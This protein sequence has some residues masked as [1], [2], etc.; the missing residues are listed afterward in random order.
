MSF[1]NLPLSLKFLILLLPPLVITFTC[2]AMG[3]AYLGYRVEADKQQEQQRRIVESYSQALKGPLWD[4]DFDT[5]WGIVHTLVH[6]PSVM[7]LRLMQNCRHKEMQWE[8]APRSA[9][10]GIG[11]TIKQ[12]IV[13]MDEHGR[14]YDVGR[15]EVRFRTTSTS[16][17]MLEQ[18]WKYGMLLVLLFSVM[19]L[20]ALVAN[21]A[22]VTAPLGRF[23]AAIAAHR[24][25]E[26][27]EMSEFEDRGDEL[28]AV[29]Q[30]YSQ[31][32]AALE[33]R[34][35]RKD[36]LASCARL[37]LQGTASDVHVLASVLAILRKAV[38]VD[39]VQLFLN[40]TNNAGELCMALELEDCG[41]DVP[42]GAGES[43]PRELP[44]GQG[45]ERWRHL[46]S[47]GE[48]VAGNM[49][50]F[51]QEE[52]VLL[53]AMHIKSCTAHPIFAGNAWR[54]F[55]CLNEAERARD[56]SQDEVVFLRTA[57]DMVGS[58]FQ[59]S[60]SERR[61][62]Q[63]REQFLSLLDGIPEPIYVSDKDSYELLFV[64]KHFQ[65]CLERDALGRKCYHVLQK[66]DAPCEFCTN[67]IIF[68][69]DGPHFWQFQ[70]PVNMRDYYVIDKAIKW[71]DGRDVRFELAIDITRLKEAETALKE[72]EEKYRLIAENISDI[73]WVLNISRD[74]FTYMS[75]S[76]S[77]VCDHAAEEVM[78]RH[79]SEAFTPE[80]CELVRGFYTRHLEELRQ[81]P[82]RQFQTIVEIQQLCKCGR[83][84]LGESSMRL[85]ATSDGEF[86]VVGVTRSIEERKKHEKLKEDVE[87]MM[88]HDL[89]SPLNAIVGL[90]P[91]IEEGGGLNQEQTEMLRHITEQGY[92][93]LQ[94]IN[95]SLDLYKLETGTYAYTPEPLCLFSIL[96]EVIL[97]VQTKYREREVSVE[98]QHHGQEVDRCQELQV[99]GERLLLY[100][101]F[102]NLID[103]AMEASRPGEHVRVE[104]SLENHD[105]FV[106]IHNQGLVPEVIR[107]RFFDKYVTY[108]KYGGTGLGTYSAKL[109]VEVMG[110][111]IEMHSSPDE[112]THITVGLPG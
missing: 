55:I 35:S 66:K 17:A 112:G 16:E 50:S 75:P 40:T 74:R 4:C 69:Q 108:G 86:E 91:L 8:A 41:Q 33:E 82:E 30:A 72:S 12:N 109:M 11:A 3:T 96:R 92:K 100:S 54:G 49:E 6:L 97:N 34:D 95:F 20:G 37:L 83:P 110:G 65:Q 73:I 68:K 26:Q 67:V 2:G 78:G 99:L 98:L 42:E 102:S 60:E 111:S 7:R 38:A 89:K 27:A 9:D 25:G 29:M 64:N 71:P 47:E 48:H 61:L 79:W 58:F 94:L 22:L 44:Y 80:S 56:W 90:P 101:I 53:K 32:M 46:F 63:E 93:M 77:S 87:R 45:H 23:K 81:F 76:I 15:L 18:V 13:Y 5:A 10:N 84:A 31:L 104:S 85:R 52:Q 107:S 43:L 103:N 57:A 1:S 19:L 21:M 106:T 62:Q 88:R 105:C 28:G 70:N 59:R 14:E 36:A 51:P 24:R 39:R